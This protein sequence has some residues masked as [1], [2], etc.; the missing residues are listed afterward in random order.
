MVIL[1]AVT[2]AMLFGLAA[3]VRLHD[4]D[5]LTIEYDTVSPFLRSFAWHDY[6]MRA[7]HG[8]WDFDPLDLLVPP[9]D[10]GMI[11]FGPGLVWSYSPLVIGADT[12]EAAFVRRLLLQSLAVAAVFAAVRRGLY[13]RGA[14]PGRVDLASYGAGL[15]A[16]IAFGFCGEPFGTAGHGDQTYLAPEFTAL[17]TVA[18]LLA[19]L[20]PGRRWLLVAMAALPW[21]AM[22]HPMAAA[23][24]PGLLVVAAWSWRGG[25]RRTVLA[26]F[27]V[28]GLMSIPEIAHLLRHLA[29]D[30]DSLA[31]SLEGVG[32]ARYAPAEV[33][34]LA[35]GTWWSLAPGGMGPALLIGPVVLAVL[36]VVLWRRS[37][38]GAASVGAALAIFAL[39]TLVSVA[40]LIAL[41]AAAGHLRPNHLR[42][43]LPVAAVATALA[44]FAV[45]RLAR[46]RT[47]LDHVP[48]AFPA[49][50]A[51]VAAT[52]LTW[53]FCAPR[54]PRF[55]HT[56][57]DLQ[58]HRWVSD[59]V[60]D[61]AGSGPRWIQS[62]LL[63]SDA[64]ASGTQP[65]DPAP[66]IV[67]HE[68]AVYLDQRM[69]GAPRAAFDPQ[70]TLYIT[71]FGRARIVGELLERMDWQVCSPSAAPAPAEGGPGS[72]EAARCVGRRAV[73]RGYETVVVGLDS[74]AVAQAWLRW[75]HSPSAGFDPVWMDWSNRALPLTLSET[76]LRLD[77]VLYG[78]P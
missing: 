48:V 70:G 72:A 39:F 24:A 47:V 49:A 43:V 38:D 31:A 18:V 21:A 42:V 6:W 35:L 33:L 46:F 2:F 10:M 3:V 50:V 13:G 63:D 28:A 56:G 78:L 53:S 75:L 69:G 68:P 37:A 16:A 9:G 17:V 4:L 20:F 67:V 34:E 77:S 64:A 30:A 66:V 23:L 61:D 7:M 26:G 44:V 40:S 29:A 73:D 27:G 55:P 32:H 71:L 76:A 22:N 11:Q 19:L 25:H 5:R 57:R 54:M 59:V 45:L 36:G 65:F 14:A 8:E 74:P 12:L 1:D 52:A 58:T 51:L 62:V 41:G 15:T 60:S